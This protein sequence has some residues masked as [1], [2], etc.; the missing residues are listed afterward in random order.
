MAYFNMG[1]K[2]KAMVYSLESLKLREELGD[3]R[4]IASSKQRIGMLYQDQGDF[5]SALEIFVSSLK[6]YEKLEE[7]LGIAL[8]YLLPAFIMI[9]VIILRHCQKLKRP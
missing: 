5:D 3:I 2:E 1:D 4:R 8:T 6:I 9:W 7:K